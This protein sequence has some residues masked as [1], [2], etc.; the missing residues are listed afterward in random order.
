MSKNNND[1]IYNKLK[2]KFTKN[3]VFVISFFVFLSIAIIVGVIL[4]TNRYWF[5]V[6][7]VV[8]IFYIGIPILTLIFSAQEKGLIR[9]IIDLFKFKEMKELKKNKLTLEEEKKFKVFSLETDKKK[10][11]I[12]HT[13]LIFVSSVLM[14]YG[15]LLLMITIPSLILFSIK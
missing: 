5:D 9:R 6:I 2:Q 10:P 4:G 11:F 14:F 15:L 12:S 3:N 1:K 7:S 13:D 8:S